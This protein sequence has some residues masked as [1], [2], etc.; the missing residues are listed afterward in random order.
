MHDSSLLVAEAGLAARSSMPVPFRWSPEQ[1][2]SLPVHVSGAAPAWLQG[3]L[4]RVAPA[5]FDHGAY[6]AAHWFDG[7]GLVYAFE[8]GPRPS[9]RQHL[10]ESRLLRESERGR[11][12]IANFSTS[13]RRG[14]VERMLSPVPRLTD[15]ANVNIIPWQG[16][17]LAMTESPRQHV[18]DGETV[19]SRGI[20]EYDDKLDRGMAMLAHP[21]FD[22]S[23]NALVNL[24]M[25]LG[26]RSE[27][28]I[29]RQ[30][31][32]STQREIEGRLPLRRAPYI[33]SFGL[34]ERHAVIIDQPMTVNPM[35]MLF[36]ERGFFEHFRWEPRRGTRLWK[37]DRQT[38]AF[39]AYETESLFCFHTVNTFED[40]GDVIF[41]FLAYDD[42]SLVD[43]FRREQLATGYPAAVPRLMRAR[44]AP[45]GSK[46]RLEQ[47]S[48]QRF[49]FPQIAARLV[50]GKPYAQ[51]YGATPLRDRISSPS[52]T[53]AST[54][55]PWATEVL[56]VELATDRVTRFSEPDYV[57]GEPVVVSRPGGTSETDG[58]L[59]CVGSHVRE[60]RSALFV[61]DADRLELLARFEVHGAIPL[62]FHGSFAFSA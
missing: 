56:R 59:L 9:Y 13:M 50:A 35:R 62:G 57:L 61:L 39:S 49:E 23:R 11:V 53:N 31:A 15:N 24:G 43:V 45:G 46:V 6:R 3:K 32:S 22:R 52:P 37:L 27:V 16:D 10:L 8:L 34:S 33:H 26:P 30:G 1:R 60:D 28:V 7:L 42:P 21:H 18:I 55:H 4:V 25:V 54:N 47:L 12:N 48:S 5:I 51:V 40:D 20:Y 44:L 41:D 17:W 38:G 36:S 29:Y 14:L 58:V 19:R 2:K